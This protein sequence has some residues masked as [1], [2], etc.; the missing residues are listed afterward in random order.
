MYHTPE[1][2]RASLEEASGRMSGW[3]TTSDGAASAMAA[4]RLPRPRVNHRSRGRIGSSPLEGAV[5]AIQEAVGDAGEHRGAARHDGFIDHHAIGMQAA[6]AAKI[7]ARGTG[8]QEEHGA[9]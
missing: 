6:A 1:R 4:I 7:A 9:G 3:S 8:P 5:T 2:S